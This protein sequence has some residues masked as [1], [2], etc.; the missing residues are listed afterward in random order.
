LK[1][2]NVYLHLK[3]KKKKSWIRLLSA[4]SSS[5][6]MEHAVL[7]PLCFYFQ[8]REQDLQKLIQQ[9]EEE[10][11]HAFVIRKYLQH[12]FGYKKT[13]PTI[14]DRIFYNGLLPMLG[15][16]IEQEPIYG[17]SILY[18]YELFALDLYSRLKQQATLDGLTSLT[19]L[20]ETIE[21]DERG[22]IRNISNLIGKIKKERPL[23]KYQEIALRTTV[24]L[25]S[26]DVSFSR[27]AFHNHSIRN[28]LLSLGIKPH[29]MDHTRRAALQKSL[30]RV[31]K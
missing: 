18:F 15:K 5:E 25:A 4:I 2:T 24:Y 27:F 28:S 16:K 10:E 1:D 30:A 31:T 3:A 26:L 12:Y 20:I 7:K 13:K 8:Y 9:S 11:K 6:A 22:H 19:S 17:L 29:V 21:H 23:K 14:S